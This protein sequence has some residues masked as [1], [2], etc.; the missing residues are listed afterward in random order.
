[1]L[2]CPMSK[3]LTVRNLPAESYA[4]LQAVAEK[5][6]RSAEAHVRFLIERETTVTEADTGGELLN[7]I[8]AAPAPEID[9]AALAALQEGRGRRSPRL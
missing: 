7:S 6:H 1:M 3:S 8:W 2:S 9:E 4:R 5:N